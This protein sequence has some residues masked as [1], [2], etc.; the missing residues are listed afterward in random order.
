MQKVTLNYAVISAQI[1]M[2]LNICSGRYPKEMKKL[3]QRSR[4]HLNRCITLAATKPAPAIAEHIKKFHD[5]LVLAVRQHVSAEL[6]VKNFLTRK[7]GLPALSHQSETTLRNS[8]Q[9]LLA[10]G[11][12]DIKA[13]LVVKDGA[14]EHA[15]ASLVRN[16]SWL[17]ALKVL[18]VDVAYSPKLREQTST[19]LGRYKVNAN[20]EAL[21]VKTPAAPKGKKAGLTADD[22]EVTVVLKD[23]V[24]WQHQVVVEIEDLAPEHQKKVRTL[25][26][27]VK[28]PVVVP[29]DK[30]PA[31]VAKESFARFEKEATAIKRAVDKEKK[32]AEARREKDNETKAL[33]ALKAMGP[34]LAVLKKNPELLEKA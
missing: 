30:T 12:K 2:M 8:I 33:A 14:M 29:A 5:D 31:E 10:L 28:K 34:L 11:E 19:S 22:F 13:Q 27:D 1:L 20:I 15:F 6:L 17:D 25:I 24:I 32:A 26:E 21:G 3:T 18:G 7:G 4:E 9:A 23:D 16:K